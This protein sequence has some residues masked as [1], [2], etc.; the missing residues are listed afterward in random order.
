MHVKNMQNDFNSL[1]PGAGKMSRRGFVATM[2]AV[3]GF[4]LATHP[5]QAQTLIETTSDGL[6]TGDTTIPTFDQSM[7][8]V[9]YA[10]PAGSHPVPVVLVVSEIFGVHEYIRD[11]ARR[12]AHAGYLAIAPE[13]FFRQG[14]PRQ[15]ESVAEIIQ[16]IVSQVPDEQVML[17]LDACAAW[18]SEKAGDASRLG[19]TGFCWGGRIT[20]LYAAHNPELR[21]GVAWYGRLDGL[22][23]EKQPQYPID[24]A[25]DLHAPVLGLY[26]GEDQGIPVEDVETMREELEQ[27]GKESLIVLYPDAPHAFH[28]DYRPSYREAEALDGW[29][30]MLEWFDRN[31]N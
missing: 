31:S 1:L 11:T 23:S 22:P 8:P 13:L 24:I 6:D 9:F 2:A 28:A 5:V 26:G 19:I 18:A 4:A 7:L 29:Q 21:A 12:L 20:W 25:A 14:D 3:T 16:T 17:D 30:K 15:I 27:A 10:R